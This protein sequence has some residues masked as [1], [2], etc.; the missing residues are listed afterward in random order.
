MLLALWASLI[1]PSSGLIVG[2]PMGGLALE[3][4]A[5][6]AT[7]QDQRVAALDALTLVERVLAAMPSPVLAFDGEQ[8][9]RPRGKL[10][11]HPTD[12]EGGR[13]VCLLLRLSPA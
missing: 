11:S 8:R 6:A 5:L 3:I 2:S 13:V 9:R 4:N 1:C 10:N 7:L 12:H